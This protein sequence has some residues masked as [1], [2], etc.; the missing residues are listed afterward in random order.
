MRHGQALVDRQALD[1]VEDGRVRRVERVGA[2][3]LARARHVQRHA[4]LEERAGL[5]R[6]RVSA[7]HEVRRL[8]AVLADRSGDVERVLHLARGVVHAE[9]QGVEVEPLRLD[10]G[11]LRDL[12]AHAD[13]EVRD[14]L[15]QRLEGCRAPAGTRSTGSVTSTASSTRTRSSRSA[16]SSP[17]RAASAWLSRPRSGPRSLPAVFLSAGASDPIWRFA[18]ASALRSPAC[19]VRTRLSAS[20]SPAEATAASAASS[21]RCSASASSGEGAVGCP[22]RRRPRGGDDV[23][24]R[25][26][27]ACLPGEGGT[28][29]S[30]RRPASTR[31][32]RRS[33]RACGARACA[34]RRHSRAPVRARTRPA[35]RRAGSTRQSRG[36]VTGPGNRRPPRRLMR[37][38][39]AQAPREQ[40]EGGPLTA[41]RVR[42]G[43]SAGSGAP[44]ARTRHR[45][46][47]RRGAARRPS[48]RGR[49]TRREPRRARRAGRPRC[50]RAGSCRGARP[51]VRLARP[52]RGPCHGEV[53]PLPGTAVHPTPAAPA[54][55]ATP[56]LSARRASAPSPPTPTHRTRRSKTPAPRSRRSSGAASC[57]TGS[58]AAARSGL[59][60]GHVFEERHREVPQLGR[61]P[62]DERCAVGSARLLRV[63]VR[64]G[65]REVV[66]RRRTR[67]ER[68]E[69]PHAP[70]SGS[71][72]GPRTGRCARLEA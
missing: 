22:V 69:Q 44:G 39:L 62:A 11:A 6:R 47:T 61:R 41:R 10:L 27:H 8:R 58:S 25:A 15:L 2:E 35:T 66:E 18:S 36:P 42:A 21:A 43:G 23:G 24:V 52:G 70:P 40:P 46:R 68:G 3:R 63:G 17:W 51:A 19:S 60:L 45:G 14:A 26:G 55:S 30:G 29:G 54:A 50:G 37:P 48:T 34:R 7:Q 64:E 56:A 59:P 33:G 71:P 57:A 72:A 32:T 53:R 1:L 28:A 38:I 5:D 67:V 49:R 9:V 31:G 65:E 4:A 12:P 13:E 16:S 20:R